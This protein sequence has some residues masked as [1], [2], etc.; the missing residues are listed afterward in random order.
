M[1]TTF[2]LYADYPLSSFDQT[3]AT[4]LSRLLEGEASHGDVTRLLNQ[5]HALGAT[6]WRHVK[7][8]VR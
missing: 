5:S 4:S 1:C 3:T 6:L 7:L 2:D 8:L